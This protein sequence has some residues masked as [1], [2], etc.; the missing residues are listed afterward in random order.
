MIVG[1]ETAVDES[2]RG[3]VVHL[4]D[5]VIGPEYDVVEAYEGPDRK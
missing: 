1:S 3:L 5:G 2:G 4:D